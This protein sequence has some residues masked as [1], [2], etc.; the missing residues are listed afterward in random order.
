MSGNKPKKNPIDPRRGQ[1]FALWLTGRPASGKST[2]TAARVEQFAE[3]AWTSPC[4]NLMREEKSLTPH[5]AYS[6][7]ERDVFYAFLAAIGQVLGDHGVPVIFVATVNLRVD[8]DHTRRTIRCF[9]EV[10][11]N[12]PL[13]ICVQRDPKGIYQRGQSDEDGRIPEAR[14][15]TNP[16]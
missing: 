9:I 8:R 11:V 7:E 6:D 12:S 1:A 3:R 4:W 15:F 5:A 13:E 16:R 10:Y 2:I 14:R